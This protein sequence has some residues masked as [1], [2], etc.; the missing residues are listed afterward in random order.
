VA[1]TLNFLT[2]ER[3]EWLASRYVDSKWDMEEFLAK[4][5]AIIKDD[6]LKVRLRV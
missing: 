1:D 5:E 3:R 4:K 6:L 2:K